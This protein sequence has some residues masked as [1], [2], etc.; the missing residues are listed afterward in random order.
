MLLKAKY[1]LAVRSVEEKKHERLSSALDEYF[2]FVDE[3]P[4]S[5]YR[6]EVEKYHATTAKLLNY[7]PDSNI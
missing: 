2:T 1:F 7:K 3:Y 5:K 4:E 6:K